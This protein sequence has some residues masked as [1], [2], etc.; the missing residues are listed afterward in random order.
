MH[1][2]ISNRNKME[3]DVLSLGPIDNDR[4]VE[5]GETLGVK[6]LYSDNHFSAAKNPLAF[7]LFFCFSSASE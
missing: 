2:H 1:L 7:F 5:D 6:T 3:S 4:S